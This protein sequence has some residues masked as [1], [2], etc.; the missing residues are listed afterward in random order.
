MR[1]HDL[2]NAILFANFH[3]ELFINDQILS[4]GEEPH[5]FQ[6]FDYDAEAEQRTSA[7]DT[8]L[9]RVLENSR[10]TQNVYYPRSEPNDEEAE[11]VETI[12]REPTVED[13]S[14]FRV[15]CNVSFWSYGLSQIHS[16]LFTTDRLRG[17]YCVQTYASGRVA[18][19]PTTLS[20]RPGSSTRLRL[21]G[22]Q[23]EQSPD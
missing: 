22:M 7:Y 21:R 17:Q 16:G 23:H 5:A 18:Q 14:L 12:L 10:N 2:T 8:L 6:E 11:R 13:P 1:Y 3:L 19:I 20:L 15:A 9:S 4:D